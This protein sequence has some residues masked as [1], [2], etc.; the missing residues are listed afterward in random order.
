MGGNFELLLKEHEFSGPLDLLLNLV[1]EQKMQISEISLSAVTEQYLGYLERM[2]ERRPDEMAD[3]LVVA[4]KLLFIK[5]RA[6]LPQLQPELEDGEDLTEQL[7]RYALFV[8]ASK[9]VGK[10]WSPAAH[11]KARTP[12]KVVD[13]NPEM[14][15]KLTSEVLQESMKKL[16]ERL[17]PAKPALEKSKID[18]TI[19]LKEKVLQIGKLLK[20]KK[21]FSFA[22]VAGDSDNKTE[23]IV[24]FLAILELMKQYKLVLTQKGA[25]HDIMISSV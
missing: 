7:E 2:S 3:F 5:S 24:S 15:P 6:L 21:R 20:S 8:R 22:A 18:R 9:H 4:T 1:T 25:G 11:M 23:T 12:L 13:E 17:K 14:P 10:A 16:I 19:S